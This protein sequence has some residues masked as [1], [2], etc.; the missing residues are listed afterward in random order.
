MLIPELTLIAAFCAL[1]ITLVNSLV[2]WWGRQDL[3]ERLDAERQ[4]QR[5][6]NSAAHGLARHIR[7]LQKQFDQGRKE[8]NHFGGDKLVK[9]DKLVEE[10]VDTLVLSESLGVS[11]S[12]AEVIAYLRPRRKSSGVFPASI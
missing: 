12:E 8:A 10:G 6:N 1:F 7:Q 4:E 5:A 11:Q 2:I 9:A 3:R